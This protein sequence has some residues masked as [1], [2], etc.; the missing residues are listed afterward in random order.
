MH[1]QDESKFTKCN[2][3]SYVMA[4]QDTIDDMMMK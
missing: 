4:E 3:V 1:T 2:D